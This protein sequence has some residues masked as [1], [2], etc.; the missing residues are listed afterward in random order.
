MPLP[1]WLPQPLDLSPKGLDATCQEAYLIFRRDFIERPF[2]FNNK[3]LHL[4][5]TLAYFGY[6]E[7]FWH[8]IS[9]DTQL[10]QK[11]SRIPDFERIFRIP[12]LRPLLSD[13][14]EKQAL[15]LLKEEYKKGF[16]KQ[17]YVWWADDIGHLFVLENRPKHFQ[18][19]SAYHI[20]PKQRS[21][22]QKLIKRYP[23]LS[24]ISIPSSSQACISF[25]KQKG[26]AY[27]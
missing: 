11:S 12:W 13:G 6:I 25:L 2:T 9:Q 15:L 17:V 21:F 20:S 24:S 5:H 7:S 10:K 26:V 8:V 14:Y 19:I 1:A 18:L 16:K 4:F 23:I 22:E 3:P 27:N